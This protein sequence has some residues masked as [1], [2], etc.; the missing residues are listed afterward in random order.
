MVLLS[1]TKDTKKYR[2][3][4][5]NTKIEKILK[6]FKN[7]FL[8]REIKKNTPIYFYKP[9]YDDY[10]SYFILEIHQKQRF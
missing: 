10:K 4:F 8:Q 3:V 2:V 7:S 5:A 6:H 1:D 9:I